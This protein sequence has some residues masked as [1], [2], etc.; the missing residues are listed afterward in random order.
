MNQYIEIVEEAIQSLGIDPTVCRT[1]ELNKWR[2]HRGQ[3]QVVM[4][5]RK[6]RTHKGEDR[7]TLVLVSPVVVVPKEE[8]LKIRLYQFLLTTSHKLIT[9]SFSFAK[10]EDGTEV[11]YISA[12]YFIGEMRLEEV[13]FMLDSMSYYAYKFS[14]ELRAEYMGQ[15]SNKEELPPFQL[16]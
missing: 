13:S 9:E 14:E 2:L 1:E 3:A 6:S 15:G 16:D 12:T 7:D 4:M 8:R 11:A 10:E 5:L